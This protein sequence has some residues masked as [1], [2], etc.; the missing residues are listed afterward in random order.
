MT[1]ILINMLGARLQEINVMYVYPQML[2][3]M[4]KKK[5]DTTFLRC[6]N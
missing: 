3:D 5:F 1:I 6:L 4:Q 2:Y